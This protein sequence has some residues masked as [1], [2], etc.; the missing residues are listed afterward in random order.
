MMIIMMIV[1]VIIIK[2]WWSPPS[3]AT[4]ASPD[5]GDESNDEE[6][7]EDAAKDPDQ[8]DAS[9]FKWQTICF[10]PKSCLLRRKGSC[11]CAKWSWDQVRR[12]CG[13]ANQLEISSL[14]LSLIILPNI[15]GVLRVIDPDSSKINV[16]FWCC[17]G[18]FFCK[19][20]FHISIFSS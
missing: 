12:G 20:P 1:T 16:Y 3:V 2:R 10:A 14:A 19:F 9:T 6:N 4:A 18:S 8:A 15:V 13:M 7:K 17:W 5:A 11:T